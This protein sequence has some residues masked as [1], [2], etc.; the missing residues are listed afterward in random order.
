MLVLS[1]AGTVT[2]ALAI[3]PESSCVWS[4]AGVSRKPVYRWELLL[5]ACIMMWCRRWY[6]YC[7]AYLV[8]QLRILKASPPQGRSFSWTVHS[9]RGDATN[10]AV[11][12]HNCK[13]HA[14]E[15]SSL[16]RFPR[17][18][19]FATSPATHFPWAP[20]PSLPL[21]ASR[22]SNILKGAAV[23]LR[24]LAPSPRPP[25]NTNQKGQALWRGSKLV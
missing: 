4:K 10:S 2:E 11:G 12:L 13:A 19:G 16:H 3:E 23:G 14:C 24:S 17:H 18:I 21:V 7:A 22:L 9:V 15:V 5:T 25:P 8:Q 6:S 1:G 20:P